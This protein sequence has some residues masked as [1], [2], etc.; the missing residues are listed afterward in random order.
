MTNPAN[1]D[2]QNLLPVQAYFSVDGT[3]QTFIG[4]GRPFYA[5][6]DPDQSG[7]HI[8]NSTINSSVIGGIT[9]AAGTFTSIAATTGTVTTAP[10]APNDIVNK[11]YVDLLATGLSWK[12]PVVCATTPSGGN[13]TLSGLQT[14][15]TVTVTAGQ[16]VLVKNQTNQADNGI[17]L[18]S[19][20]AWSRALDANSWDELVGAIVFITEGGQKDSAWYSTTQAG[21]TLGVTPIIWANFTISAIYT[22]GTGLQLIGTEFSIANTSVVAATYGSASRN[23]VI[24]VNAQGQITSA[25]DQDISIAG[26]QVTGNISGNAANVTG[27]VAVLNGGTGA[28]TATNARTNLG[29]AASGANSDIT[30]ITGLTGGISTPTFIQWGNGTGQ[31]IVAGKQFYDPATGSHNMVMGGGNITQQVGEEIFV[32]GKASAAITEGQ[33]I[34]KTGTVGASGVITFGPAPASLTNNDGIIGIAT[35]NIALNGFGR[36]TYFGVIHGIDTSGSTAGQTWADNDTLWYNPAGSGKLTNVKP[37]APNIKYAVATVINASS[38][39]SGSIQV[40]LQ[41]GS[42]LGGTDSNVQLGTL[43]NLD[44]IQYDSALGYFKN[45]AASSITVGATAFSATFNN[46]GTGDASGT[47]FNGS[48]AKTISYNTIGAPKADGTG[49]SGTWSISISGNAATATKATNIAGGAAGS[50]PYNTAADTT[51]FLALGTT[52]YVLTAGASAPQYVA[53]STLSVGSATNATNVGVTDNTSSSATWY[54]TLVSTTT[55]NLPITTSS[56]KFS[57]VPSTGTLNVPVINAGSSTA[58]TLQSAGTTA[59]YADTSQNV[60]IGTISPGAKLDVTG[61][62]AWFTANNEGYSIY[63]RYNNSTNGCFIGSPV[64]DAF[65][66]YNGGGAENL[67]VTTDGTVVLKG[68]NTSATGVGI[69][70]PASQSASSDANTLDD[71][72]EGTWTPTIGGNGVAGS[73]TYSVQGGKYTKVGRLVTASFDVATTSTLSGA[74][75]V[76]VIRGLPFTAIGSASGLLDAGSGAIGYFNGISGANYTYTAY[77]DNNSNFIVPAYGNGG[78][79]ITYLAT[80][81][82]V[83]GTRISGIITYTIS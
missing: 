67:R 57:F 21:G 71:Y 28:S 58:L 81:N 29:A 5:V 14:I 46:S 20:G 39:G 18:A 80:G 50:L 76:G 54:P 36:I 63:M 40:D 45:V 9:P 30:S 43:S 74:T 34:V 78:T 8:T 15:D 7:L 47:T 6:P 73:A 62:R 79:G 70:F 23:S 16:R 72:E 32:Y 75:G 41:P 2:V 35:E 11:Y 12:Q 77:I 69:T 31:S 37:S 3:F 17:Y 82:I 10:S 83:N 52:N 55:G 4:Q 66:V 59:I 25:Y 1:S 53:Q 61:G 68:G 27:I 22:A 19:A 38:G 24:T 48:A 56:T 33:L 64:A 26:S 49:A 44:L 42:T 13:I 60:G 65:S 51:S